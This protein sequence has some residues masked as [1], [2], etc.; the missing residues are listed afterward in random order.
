MEKKEKLKI[1]Y[2]DK[3]IIIV[4]KKDGLLTISTEK[5]KTNT[6]YRKVSDYVKKK[7]KNNKIYIVHRLD[8]DT[9]GIVLFAKDLKTK[10]ELQDNWDKIVRKYYSV[11]YGEIK[12]SGV[13][14]CYLRETN[15]YKTYITNN[16]TL[17]KYSETIYK[18]LIH[19]NKYTLLDI[20][21]KTG[22]KNQIRVSLSSI[23]HPVLGDKK[24]GND[25]KKH[26]RL[27][28][29]AYYLG[30]FHPIIKEKIIVEDTIPDSFMKIVK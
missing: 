8:R 11:V 4:N 1:L 9:S 24:Y 13:I 29:H 5:E 7:H 22:R 27:Y 2:E 12:K 30:F 21:I 10:K 3:Y 28:L 23:N 25:I 19:T 26:L 20:N 14:K 17:G 6:L 18:P 16:K 15:T